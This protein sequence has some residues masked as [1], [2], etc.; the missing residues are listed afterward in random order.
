[1]NLVKVTSLMGSALLAAAV[2]AAPAL[3]F[4]QATSAD[5]SAQVSCKDGTTAAHGGRAWIE[6][7]P[8]GVGA[9]FVIALPAAGD[10]TPATANAKP[11]A[12]AA[13]PVAG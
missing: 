9:L 7:A 2:L 13:Q 11:A 8:N 12:S 4:A 1:M 3:S 5:A 10:Y 6:N